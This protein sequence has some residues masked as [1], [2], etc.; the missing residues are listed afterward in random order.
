MGLEEG[1]DFNPWP[2]KEDCNASL[3][4]E[5]P[6]YF[7]CVRTLYKNGTKHDT[8]C[9]N[10]GDYCYVYD[11]DGKKIQDLFPN[12]KIVYN[13]D[14]DTQQKTSVVYYNADG[15]LRHYATYENGK[16][17]ETF[18]ESSSYAYTIINDVA[19]D[20]SNKWWTYYYDNPPRAS[21]ERYENGSHKYTLTYDSSGQI[22]QVRFNQASGVSAYVYYNAAG[23]ITSSNCNSGACDGWTPPSRDSFTHTLPE[24]PQSTCLEDNPDNPIV[25]GS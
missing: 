23:E 25:C 3:Y 6:N 12:S 22:S 14:P 4:N 10:V 18:W 16:D 13:Y 20:G 7:S 19:G 15:S 21:V 5:N 2:H 9:R 11:N 1:R 17:K 24:R 8:V